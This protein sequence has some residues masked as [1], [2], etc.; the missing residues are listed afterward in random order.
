MYNFVSLDHVWID[1][2]ACPRH[3]FVVANNP[4][5]PTATTPSSLSV[6]TTSGNKTSF[7]T[8]SQTT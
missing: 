1:A 5:P 4:P 7:N 8:N 3:L 6:V 2:V